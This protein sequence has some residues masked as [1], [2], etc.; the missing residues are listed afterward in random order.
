MSKI[1]CPVCLED[2]SKSV[3][4]ECKHIFCVKCIFKWIF[5]CVDESDG[6]NCPLC[7]QFIRMKNLKWVKSSPDEEE[8]E[9]VEF[10]GTSNSFE[11]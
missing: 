3:E 7:R 4:T 9:K 6:I 2:K 5:C 11:F 8:E 10:L 1:Q